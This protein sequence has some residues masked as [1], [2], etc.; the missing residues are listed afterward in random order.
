MPAGPGRL[1]DLV[2]NV[3][4]AISSGRTSAS[5]SE[6]LTQAGY[7]QSS[8]ATVYLGSKVLLFA[9]GLVVSAALSLSS[10]LETHTKFLIIMVASLGLFFV[11]NMVVSSRRSR[12]SSEIRRHLSDAI[13][14]LEIC[15]SSGMGIDMAWNSVADE[16]RAVSVTL[17]D[18]MALTNLEIHLGA[19][20]A[21]A[22]RHMAKRTGADELS[23]LVAVLVQSDRFGTSI[24]DALRNF[25]TSMRETRSQ[26]AQE[27]AEKMAIKLIFPMI[28]FIFPAAV[29]VMAG[30][31][32]IMLFRALSAH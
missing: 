26:R 19:A 11:P 29:L 21:D 32:F 5:L 12:R 25:A 16:V 23:S 8:A 10:D 17:A 30:P 27:T 22:M 15:A 1:T 6:T 20:R 24:T 9:L 4:T 7:H 13:D 14:L 3:G 28:L 2:G 18:E 31:A